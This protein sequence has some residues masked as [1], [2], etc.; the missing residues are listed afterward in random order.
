MIILQRLMLVQMS[1]SITSG[2]HKVA[3]DLVFL[4]RNGKVGHND[5]YPDLNTMIASYCELY[6]AL[7]NNNTNIINTNLNIDLNAYNDGHNRSFQW[8]YGLQFS[9]V[10]CFYCRLGV[11]F[12]VLLLCLVALLTL[13][14]SKSNPFPFPSSAKA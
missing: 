3:Q 10:C 11:F 5:T 2:V 1:G 4:F 8:T 6:R 7:D 9:P 12:F 13:S 14:H